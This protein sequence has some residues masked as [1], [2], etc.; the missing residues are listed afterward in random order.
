MIFKWK[1]SS[2]R[3]DIGRVLLWARRGG[4]G[5]NHVLYSSTIAV[6]Q[7]VQHKESK[8]LYLAK[9][10]FRDK[11]FAYTAWVAK[12]LGDYAL[13][14][15]GWQDGFGAFSV[16]MSRKEGVASYIRNQVEQHTKETFQQ[17]YIRLLDKHEIQYDP[18]YVWD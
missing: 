15:N 11:V 17:E 10:E 1:S 4:T 5:A 6:R 13:E 18:K 12:N 8:A 16:S 7:R 9:Q 14:I 3:C 2:V